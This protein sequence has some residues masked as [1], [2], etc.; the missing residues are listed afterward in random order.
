MN[1]LGD[2]HTLVIHNYNKIQLP[3]LFETEV[4]HLE[5]FFT[6]LIAT[7]YFTA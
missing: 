3:I 2:I 5:F 4:C 1:D 6:F 7:L